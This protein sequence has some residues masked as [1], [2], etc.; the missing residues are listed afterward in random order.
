MDK[1]KKMLGSSMPSNLKRLRL[2]E[3]LEAN[4]I[5]REIGI[6]LNK[7]IP[8]NAIFSE[9]IVI[10]PSDRKTPQILISAA[11]E[12]IQVVDEFL[13]KHDIVAQK[14]HNILRINLR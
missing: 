10:S 9:K 3:A 8:E 13:L 2:K 6:S 7:K 11:H 5:L 4:K 14:E 12:V 1:L